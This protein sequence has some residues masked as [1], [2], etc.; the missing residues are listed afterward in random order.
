MSTASGAVDRRSGV[1]PAVPWVLPEFS[2]LDEDGHGDRLSRLARLALD[3]EVAVVALVQGSRYVVVGQDGRIPE[4]ELRVQLP[5]GRL[6]HGQAT[7]VE[8]GLPDQVW[9]GAYAGAPARVHGRSVTATAAVLRRGVHSWT[10]SDLACLDE[11][12]LLAVTVVRAG[13]SDEASGRL[14]QLVSR[15]EAPLA[16]LGDAV[17]RATELV[18]TPQDPRLPR[19]ADV[20]RQRLEVVE[21]VADEL[22]D[23][24]H[25]YPEYTSPEASVDLCELVRAMATR[26]VDGSDLPF[27]LDLP[28]HPV[29]VRL[30]AAM[31]ERALWRLLLAAVDDAD[32]VLPA[33]LRL[34]GA[35]GEATVLVTIPG[36]GVPPAN[37]VRLVGALATPGPLTSPVS[38]ALDGARL[39]V[40]CDGVDA[41]TDGSGTV[42]TL[43]LGSPPEAVV[44]DPREVEP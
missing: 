18:E 12:A 42:I 15:L 31:L 38:I 6:L 7:L 19:L 43:V 25:D 29:W 34:T 35:D 26:A 24:G 39:V 10:Q 8:P 21:Q 44:R 40:R 20:V 11:L 13:L 30:P 27:G 37:L 22:G 9:S 4:L 36:L 41:R 28:G 2:W 14:E 1:A 17:R 16:D 33:G 3:A 32:P 5:T 23:I